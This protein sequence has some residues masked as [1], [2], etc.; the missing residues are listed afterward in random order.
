M[1]D[2]HPDPFQD[3][4]RA[5][6]HPPPEPPREAMWAAI[7]TALDED[8]PVAVA[9]DRRRWSRTPLVAAAAGLILAAGFGLGRFSVPVADP[10][11]TSAEAPPAESAPE[12]AS[13]PAGDTGAYRFAAARHLAESSSFLGRVQTQAAG[14]SVPPDAGTWAADLLTQ[15]RLILDSPA[16]EEEELRRLL[17]DLELVLVQVVH[18]SGARAS[19]QP[20]LE[21]FEL[22]Q[23]NRGLRQ[24]EVLLRIRRILPPMLASD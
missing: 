11:V 24:N 21:Q 17:E 20:E 13:R 5:E 19:G 18:V 9:T 8:V 15:T 2:G 6:F 16:A 10:G 3:R 22:T 23:L 7:R 12:V 14:G 1:S 4:V